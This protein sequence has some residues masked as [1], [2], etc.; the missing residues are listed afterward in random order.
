MEQAIDTGMVKLLFLMAF[1][2]LI[3]V[4]GSIVLIKLMTLIF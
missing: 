1:G 2:F 3:F 4:A